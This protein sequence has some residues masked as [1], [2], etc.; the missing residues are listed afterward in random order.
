VIDDA[1]IAAGR[2]L[3]RLRGCEKRKREETGKAQRCANRQRTV[4]LHSSLGVVE[5]GG[6][7][8]GKYTRVRERGKPAAAG[9]ASMPPASG[10]RGVPLQ[11]CFSALVIA[12][13]DGVVNLADEDFAVADAAGAGRAGDCLFGFFS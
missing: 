12:D 2:W 1:V 5:V 7:I 9:L 11:S 10:F 3:R 13:A 6:A 4:A 8:G